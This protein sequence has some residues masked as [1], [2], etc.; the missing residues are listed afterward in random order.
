[1]YQRSLVSPVSSLLRRAL[2]LSIAVAA[3]GCGGGGGGSSASVF[4]GTFSGRWFS[5]AN[6]DGG[7]ATFTTDADG[8]VSGLITVDG[9]GDSANRFTGQVKSNGAY[10]G[11]YNDR[12]GAYDM[13]G[14]VTRSASGQTFILFNS[15]HSLY[16]RMVVSPE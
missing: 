15:G 11:K 16:F 14:T 13:T 5:E 10:S 4:Q 6:A 2:V 7:S 12:G 8:K 3:V 9:S 1:M